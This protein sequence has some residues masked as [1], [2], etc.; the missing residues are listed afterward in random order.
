METG[1]DICN[2]KESSNVLNKFCLFES[3]T[4]SL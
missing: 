4:F 2:V 1:F 3:L